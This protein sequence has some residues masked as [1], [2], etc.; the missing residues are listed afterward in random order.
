[1]LCG[2]F[3]F[4]HLMESIR[5][6][7]RLYGN[8]SLT[9]WYNAI[10]S[11]A[12]V[13][14]I[15]KIKGLDSKP[16]EFIGFF[17]LKSETI[18]SQERQLT[19]TW[20]ELDRERRSQNEKYSVF[21][22]THKYTKNSRKRRRNMKKT[23]NWTKDTVRSMMTMMTMMMKK[24]HIHTWPQYIMPFHTYKSNNHNLSRETASRCGYTLAHDKFQV[25]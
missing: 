21:Q 13:A 1:M 12:F 10:W 9:I 14:A 16:S 25:I 22:H 15:V 20:N 23:L 6:F 7:R 8:K 19:D 18:S 17:S 24:T 11:H 5:W 4:I 3:F 2:R